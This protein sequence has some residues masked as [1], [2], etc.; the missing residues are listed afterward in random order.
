MAFATSRA[1]RRARLGFAL[2]VWV[3]PAWASAELTHRY[4]FNDGTAADSVGAA[5]GVPVNGPQINNG[6][7][8]FANPGFVNDPLVGKYIDLP[9]QIARTPAL[10]LETWVT[11]VGVGLFEEIASFGT[12]TA[13]ELQP[14]TPNPATGG[15][16][17]TDYV[18]L[19]PNLNGWLTGTLRNTGALEQ[20]L[21]GTNPQALPQNSEHHVAY[22]VDYPNRI[23]A[24]YLDGAEIG[25]RTISIDPS[26]FDQVNDWLARSQWSPDAFFNGSINE[27][28]IYDA[29]LSPGE[30]AASFARG[31]DVV[32][33]PSTSLALTVAGLALLRR[34][35]GTRR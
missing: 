6:R 19:I 8:H 5:H 34:T 4:S 14:G 30:V 33:E 28:R 9:N 35:R 22:T 17:G 7:V 13:G 29:A 23:A 24:L 12:G 27:F 2:L 26:Q 25:R 31:P 20:P 3:A 16:I 32:P 21:R 15:V 18:A 1:L 10:T 11:Y